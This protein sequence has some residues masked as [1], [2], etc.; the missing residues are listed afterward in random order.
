MLVGCR[1]VSVAPANVSGKDTDCRSRAGPGHPAGARTIVGRS[2]LGASPEAIKAVP[3]LRGAD[4]C[5]APR[6]TV[7]NQSPHPRGAWS[8]CHPS[9]A[10]TARR[11]VWGG[12]FPG[13]RTPTACSP[14]AIP[15]RPPRGRPRPQGAHGRFGHSSRVVPPAP[16]CAGLGNVAPRLASGWTASPT[17]PAPERGSGNTRTGGCELGFH[18]CKIRSYPFI[19]PF[20]GVE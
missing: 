5:F 8:F 17:Y 11:W 20:F 1:W 13:L 15:T 7:P 3:R 19:I 10:P 16:P 6:W 14:R 2:N 18:L 12:R 9:R 4:G